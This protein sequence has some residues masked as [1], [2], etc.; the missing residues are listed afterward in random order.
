MI[1]R[2]RSLLVNAALALAVAVVTIVG[3][4]G[5]LRIFPQ[6]LPPEPRLRVHWAEQ[7]KSLTR[8]D[9]YIGYLYPEH[10]EWK[11]GAGEAVFSFTTD[12]HGFRNPSPWPPGAEIVAV[13][14]SEVFGYGVADDSTWTS[15]LSRS[16]PRSHLI[17]L[18]LPGMAPEQYMRVY[19]RFG[20]PL[21]PKVLLFGLFPGNDV[22]DQGEFAAWLDAG[23]PGNFSEFKFTR[24]RKSSG[25]QKLVQRMY[26]YW[27]LRATDLDKMQWP[28]E[29]AQVFEDGSRIRFTP[30]FLKSQAA[31]TVPGNKMFERVL[32][33]VEQTRTSASENGTEFLVLLFPEKEEVYLPLRGE[34]VP[35]LI[36][37]FEKALDE[38]GIPY[39]DLSIPM[40]NEARKGRKL[41]FE[42]DGHPNA[43]GYRV[44]A[45]AVLS[46][47]EQ[48]AQK[49]GLADWQ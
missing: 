10:Y 29:K 18:G 45:Q 22:Q 25:F 16:L 6:L 1:P 2:I 32:E 49:Y 43:A 40:Q 38:R 21:H 8:A 12:E 46:H 28:P 34:Q 37:P 35:S 4:E 14:D 20:A 31:I 3:V 19:E 36:E 42:V 15:V 44:I 11:M 23:S 24:G 27:L 30:S 48:N 26:L 41:F 5:A 33:V 9:P 47:L 39:V 17:N 7:G 13:G